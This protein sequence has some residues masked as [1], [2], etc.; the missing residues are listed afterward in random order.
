MVFLAALRVLALGA[1]R[2]LEAYAGIARSIQ[3]RAVVAAWLVAALATAGSLYFS[4][5]AKFTPC[6]LCWYQRIGMSPLVLSLG[7]AIVKRDR[8]APTG[9]ATLAGIG[10]VIAAYHVALEWIPSL[11]TGACAGSAPR[12]VGLVRAL[13]RFR[14][15]C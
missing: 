15:P 7:V 13:G 1:D 4:E 3:A 9:S 6:T 14:L 12:T 2:A 10:A 5:M 11:D 8:R